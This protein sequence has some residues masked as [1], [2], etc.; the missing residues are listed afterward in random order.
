MKN[1]AIHSE[2]S[3]WST[4]NKT[5]RTKDLMMMFGLNETIDQLSIANSVRWYGH[6]LARAL[7]FDVEGQK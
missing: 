6:V 5:K 4:A 7:E 3:M 2:N 1:R